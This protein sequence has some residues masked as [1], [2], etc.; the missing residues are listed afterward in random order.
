MSHA[1][2]LDRRARILIALAI[3]LALF[4]A[5]TDAAV[6]SLARVSLTRFATAAAAEGDTG[7]AAAAAKKPNV[8]VELGRLRRIIL[9]YM[10]T[11]AAV[12]L[13]LSYF[14]MSGLVV[15]PLSRVT[16]AV[17]QVAGGRLEAEAPIAGSGELI[18][19]AVSFNRMTRTLREQRAELSAQ[20]G[21]LEKSSAELRGAQEQLIRAAKLA[22]VGTLAAGVAHEIGNPLAGVLGLLDA[23]D[24]ET[25][26]ALAKS[27]R[28]LIRKEVRRIDRTIAD[29]L[30]YARPSRKEALGEGSSC[31]PLEAIEHVRALLGAQKLFDDIALEISI[32]ESAEVAMPRDDFTQLVVNLLL[33]AAH[34]MNGR[35]A[36]FVTSRRVDAFRP[37]F[38]AV[39]REAL[40][41]SVT[42]EGPGV[43]PEIAD[44]IFDPFFTTKADKSG[45]GLGLAICQSLCAR[46][47]AEIALDQAHTRG[48]KFVVTIP[49]A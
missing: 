29:L 47:G 34:A 17:E 24:G 13:A 20:L 7:T 25:D 45:T 19:L 4:I 2:A 11:G 12:A 23:L 5:L 26:P 38:A 18:D 15:G 39:E 40:S 22:S 30:A 44:R 9:F 49:L 43:P 8:E 42:D 48:A 28:E 3:F 36:I 35:G 32:S 41:I 6:S 1:S 14:A 27:Y 31:R 37:A 16:R 21:A 10:I 33:N 46:A